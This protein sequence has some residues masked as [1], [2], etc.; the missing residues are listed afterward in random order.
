MKKGTYGKLI[1]V[2][3]ILFIMGYTIATLY[4]FYKNQA[5]P[6]V[7]TPLVYSFFGGELVMLFLKKRFD[8]KSNNND[9]N[10]ELNNKGEN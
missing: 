2:F 3:C 5:E 7:L 1:V 9:C 8:Q 4:S 6:T 10:E